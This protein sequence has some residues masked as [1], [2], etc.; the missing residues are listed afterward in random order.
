[1]VGTVN[2]LLI[3]P[4]ELDPDGM[5]TLTGR[6]AEHLRRVLRVQP[7]QWLRA[8]IV[9]GVLADAQVLSVGERLELRVQPRSAPRIPEIDV[10]IAV[11]RPK[12]LSRIVQSLASFGV[13]RIDI[14]NA[15][16]VDASYFTSHKLDEATLALDARLGCE[17]GVQTYLPHVAVHR[18]FVT[19]VHDV[20]GP[21]LALEP[22]RR[23]LVAHPAAPA[24]VEVVLSGNERSPLVLAVGPDGGF[25]EQEVDTLMGAGGTACHFGSAVLRSEVAVVA[26]LSQIELLRRLGSSR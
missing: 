12:A 15:W 5:V 10:V 3:E 6:R 14:I 21:R 19:F 9:R 8:G 18:L 25:T 13:R 4:G 11:P 16:R 17:Q 23:L 7:G 24:A 22:S 20:L 1:V 2:L 26:I